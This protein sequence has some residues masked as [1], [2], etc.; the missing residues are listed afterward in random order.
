VGRMMQLAG[1]YDPESGAL[2]YLQQAMASETDQSEL[3]RL[4]SE[5]LRTKTP[6]ADDPEIQQQII[7]RAAATVREI[8][9][10]DQAAKLWIGQIKAETGELETAVKYFTTWENPVWQPALDYSLARIYEQQGKLAEAIDVYR[11][12]E[13]PQRHGNLLRARRLETLL[14]DKAAKN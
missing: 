4:I 7:D 11:A 6:D 14:N 5:D 1:N 9:R 8:Q 10:A 13:S 3:L 12:S 2:R